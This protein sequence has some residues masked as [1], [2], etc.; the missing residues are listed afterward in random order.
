M[1]IETLGIMQPYF[2]PYLGYFDLINYSDQWIVFDI[3]QYIRHG[4]MNRNRIHHPKEG[5]LYIIVPLKKRT[6]EVLIKDVVISDDPKWK[7]KILGQL[8]HYRKKAPYF[9]ETYSIVED[10]L[11][12]NE[13]LLSRFNTVVLEKTCS[14]LGI[15]FKY[16][17]F[18]EM[19]LE[20]DEVSGPGDWALKIS[21]NLRAREYVNPSGGWTIFDPEK[22]KSAGIKLTIRN[23]PP[24]EYSC[25]GYEY[26]PHLSI[27]DVMMFNSPEEIKIFLD[28]QKRQL[29]RPYN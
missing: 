3:V 22:F 15:D 16:D 18:S 8:N 24:F 27:I 26:I 5:D 25:R 13:K 1:A 29:T 17:Y 2:L 9:K 11:S 28:A 19:N 14:I 7:A 21:E 23:I 10:C 12:I 6:R 20:F 4:W